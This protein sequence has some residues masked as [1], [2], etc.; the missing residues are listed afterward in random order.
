M[1]P[2]KPSA[3]SC[4]SS[5]TRTSRPLAAASSSACAASQAGFFRLEGTVASIR[6]RQPAPPTATARSKVGAVSVGHLGEHDPADRRDL[7]RLGPPV[8]RERAEHHADH[9]RFDGVGG[10]R[11]DRWSPRH[12]GWSPPWPAPLRRAGSRPAGR[13]PHRPAARPGDRRCRLCRAAPARET[14]SPVLPV[15]WCA[16]STPSRS[17]A[18]ASASAA[19]PGP[20]T[21]EPSS[22][23]VGRARRRLQPRESRAAE[24]R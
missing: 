17:V 6:E 19:A 12:R 7:G 10:E 1:M 18:R 16:S 3:A 22:R 4:C 13:R 5:H 14:I 24:G 8:E 15:A 20:S 9:E 2:P 11:G 21:N 23:P